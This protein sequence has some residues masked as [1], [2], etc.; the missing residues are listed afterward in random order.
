MIDQRVKR[1]ML[2]QEHEGQ[3]KA[4]PPSAGQFAPI[5]L[6]LRNG[7]QQG[8]K[9]PKWREVSIVVSAIIFL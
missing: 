6:R 8:K 5:T 1:T 4:L 2:I 9:L 3:G 7:R